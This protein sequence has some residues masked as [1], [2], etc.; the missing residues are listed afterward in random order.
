MNI[1]KKTE[2]Q[3][4]LVL[5]EPLKCPVCRNDQFFT[6]RAQLNTSVATFFNLDWANR[7]AKC[8]VCSN[9][10]HISWFLGDR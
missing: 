5:G 4:I 1:F 10:T 7:S 2:P 6:R 8:F 3:T 9:C